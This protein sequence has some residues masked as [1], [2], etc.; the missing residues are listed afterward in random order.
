VVVSTNILS[1][2]T[3]MGVVWWGPTFLFY[4]FFHWAQYLPGYTATRLS[5][6]VVATQVE[7]VFWR[8]VESPRSLWWVVW[9]VHMRVRKFIS[10]QSWRSCFMLSNS[11]KIQF[12]LETWFEMLCWRSF[13]SWRGLFSWLLSPI[14]APGVVLD[15]VGIVT[16]KL[17]PSS[18]SGNIILLR[19]SFL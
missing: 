3:R 8:T 7:T 17:L 12:A 1:A 6:M 9:L 19:H 11:K 13:H 4:S 14:V 10:H 15:I 18:T 5:G 16:V 2:F